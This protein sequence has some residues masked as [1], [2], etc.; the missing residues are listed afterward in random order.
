MLSSTASMTSRWLQ[1]PAHIFLPVLL[2]TSSDTLGVAFNAADVFSQL[3]QTC[4]PWD[5]NQQKL[6]GVGLEF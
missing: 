1:Y 4:H 5:Y 6:G 3:H 2:G